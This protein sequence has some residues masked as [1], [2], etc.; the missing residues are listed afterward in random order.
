[1][2]KLIGLWFLGFLV[3]EFLGFLV[4][5]IQPSFNVFKRYLVHITQFP[6]HVVFLIDIDLISK[7]FKILLNGTSGIPN[8]CLFES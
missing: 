2:K 4:S 5:K 7:I 6:F 1:M 3:S 8:A